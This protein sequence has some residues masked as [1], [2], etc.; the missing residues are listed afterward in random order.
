M[1]PVLRCVDKRRSVDTCAMNECCLNA[2]TY[3]HGITS[4]GEAERRIHVDNDVDI[5]VHSSYI[6]SCCDGFSFIFQ[7]HCETKN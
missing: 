1:V 4:H 2:E 5:D 3:N 6:D 7:W